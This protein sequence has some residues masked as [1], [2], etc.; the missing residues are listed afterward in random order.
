M[1]IMIQNAMFI[2][3]KILFTIKKKTFWTIKK[4]ENYASFYWVDIFRVK[5]KGVKLKL[6]LK[7]VK[8]L[9]FKA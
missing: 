8:C 5:L 2:Y 1:I 4:Q 9:I 3:N 6:L 7:M